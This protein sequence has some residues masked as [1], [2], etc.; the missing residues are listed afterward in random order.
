MN[1]EAVRQ[2]EKENLMPTYGRFPVALV[3]GKGVYATDTEGKQYIDFGSGIGV[4]ALGW[5]DEGWVKAVSEQ[6]ATLQHI[7]NLYYSPVQ[8]ELA[9]DLCRLSGFSKVFFGN[10]GAEA[11]ECAIKLARKYGESRSKN[12]KRILT[13]C[14]SFH[15]R[16]ITTLAATG[17][18]EFHHHFDPFTEGF[19][20]API[21]DIEKVKEALTPDT[22]AVMIELIQGEG[23][24]FMLDKDFV[25]QLRAL[26]DETGTLLMVDEVQTGVGRTGTLYCFEQYGIRPDV[27]TSAK[28][29]GGGMPIGACLCSQELGQVLSGGMHGSTFGGGPVVCAAARYMLSRIAQPDFLQE[30]AEKGEYLKKALATVPQLCNVRGMGLM[31]G[32]D[33]RPETGLTS[34][35]VANRCLQNGMLVLTAH[36]AVRFLPP[37]TITRE[38]ID[39]GV[40][41]LKNALKGAGV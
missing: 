4:N 25:K 19:D 39:E 24:V 37:L 21:N 14:N 1:F 5:C 11:N 28:G 22:C 38:E 41:I 7:S 33:V 36:K 2:Q 13:L 8:T 30:V 15:G 29:L 9:A 32:A 3:K 27:V 10:S 34:G 6:A 18:D 17:Q 35:D 20:Y 23:G 40:A 16:T 12:C 31:V 26:C